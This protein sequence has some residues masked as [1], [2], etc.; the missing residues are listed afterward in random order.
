MKLTGNVSNIKPYDVGIVCEGN[1]ANIDS[2]L[3]L[4]KMK[5][6]PIDVEN[7]EIRFEDATG[8]FEY[9]EI[10]RGDMTEELGERLDI[11][12]AKMTEMSQ[13]QDV[14]IEKLDNSTSILKENTSILKENT[15]VLKENTSILIDFKNETNENLNR[16]TNI[17]T[18]HDVDAQE[19]I[20]NLTV[21]I[22]DIK[23]RLTHLESAIS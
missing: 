20:A 10:K 21:E 12:N 1:K 2:F 23:D 6:Y 3:R 7:L 15:S 5:E 17:M 9:F 13:K 11:A 14:M 16:L 18:K 19:R 22:S 8:E 4:I